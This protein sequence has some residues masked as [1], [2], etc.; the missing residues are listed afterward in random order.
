MEIKAVKF[1]TDGFY[2]Q[3]FAFGGEEGP[4]KFDP[5]VRYR[6]SLQ[7]YLIDTGDE[8][9]LVDTGLPR[10]TPEEVPNVTSPAYTGRDVASYMEAFAALGY[11]PEQVTTILLTP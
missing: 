8:V 10:G 3:P 6:G 11:Q 7:N 5:S 2:S 1:R 4:Q 9:I